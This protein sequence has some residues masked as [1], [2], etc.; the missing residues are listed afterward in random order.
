MS[1][2]TQIGLAPSVEAALSYVLGGVTGLIFLL[3]EK[4]DRF[5]RF[6]AMQSLITSGAI[7]IAQIF[8]GYIPY[9]SI[10]RLLLSPLSLALW[11]VLMVKAYQGERCKLPLTGDVAE[12]LLAK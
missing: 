7:T 5:V 3:V 1:E 6:H 4:E 9:A 11:I 8:L 12:S 2:K 10:L